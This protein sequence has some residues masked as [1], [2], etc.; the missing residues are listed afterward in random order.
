MTPQQLAGL[1]EREAAERLTEFGP[2]ALP[3]TGRRGFLRIAAETVRE[4]MFL[5]MTGAAVLYLLLGD[6][7]EG[8]FLVGCAVAS[9]GLVVMQA[10]RS[11]RAL[12]ALRDLAQPLARV[13]RDGAERRLPAQDLVPGDIILVG[14]G[15]RLP[16]DGRLVGGEVLAVD[17]SALTGESAPVTKLPSDAESGEAPP[18]GAQSTPWLYAGAMVVRGQGVARITGTGPR[19]A[20]GRIGASLAAIRQEPTPLQK[21]A[22]RMAGV[23]GAFALAF[24]V[25]VAVS[26]GLI[27]HDWIG[28]GLSGITVAIAL[29]PEEFPMVLAV[30]MALG[31]WRLA[32]HHVLTRRSAVIETLGAATVL[33]VDKTGTLTENRMRVAH[34]WTPTADVDIPGDGEAGLDGDL[35]RLLTLAALASA[36]QPADPMD[37]AIRFLEATAAGAAPTLP[38]APERAWPLRAEL[39]AVIQV[40]RGA[41]DRRV[42]AA[43][44]APEAIFELCRLPE[45]E[46][47]RLHAVVQSQA[48]RGLRLLGVASANRDGPFGED[49]AAT[50]FTFAGLIGFIDPLRADVPA[51]LAEA[52]SAGIAVVMITGD[53][54]ATALAIARAAGLDTAAGVLTG[55]EVAALSIEALAERL[56]TARVFARIA[57]E[58]KLRLV[59]AFKAAGEVVAMTGDGINDAPALEAAHI[60][61]AMGRKG[62]DVAREAADLVLLDDSFASIVGG[63]RLGRRIFAN[64]RRALVYIVA[65]HV[66]IAGLAL[67]PILLGL[68]PL[69][70]PM[71]VVL[72]ELAID[73]IC[74][75]V[76]EAEPSEERAMRRPPRP[77]AE[78]LFGLPQIGLAVLQGL[79][80]LAGVG[81]V[82][83]WALADHSEPVARGAAFTALVVGNLVLALSDSAAS[84]HIFS[85]QKRIY[86]LIAGAISL[87]LAAVLGLAPI[88]ALFR[89]ATPTPGLLAVSLLVAAAA[90]GWLP[91]AAW[92]RRSV[93]RRSGA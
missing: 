22:G 74:A 66:P 26:Y 90:G 51:A 18:P 23:L 25:L 62:T 4:P 40:W 86:W 7:S 84:A 44:G 88:S 33:C 92:A 50:P 13:V 45:G 19:S 81:S 1:T 61:I 54:P 72:M 75:L 29:I 80:L 60:G 20:L 78:A 37:K 87:L 55:A 64:L 14:E 21:T 82:Y 89:I 6:L 71:H 70:M 67:G 79:G 31:A 36:V 16:A 48:D 39:L 43:K 41:D 52:R 57:P 15:E 34:L 35:R 47:A 12:D 63:V 32:T 69:L 65:I 76:F 2:N 56:R 85:A 68:P 11:E 28:G 3:R 53:H 9:I 17:E 8:L 93:L 83:V 46:V 73:P 49:P 38:A 10:T 91:L 58:Q 59:E 27:R 24:C 42:A 5:L 30:F 77:A